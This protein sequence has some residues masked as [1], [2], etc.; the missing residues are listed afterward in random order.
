MIDD[1]VYTNGVDDYI[2][3]KGPKLDTCG[4]PEVGKMDLERKLRH[5]TTCCLFI[6]YDWNNVIKGS[7]N[8]YYRNLS[9]NIRSGQFYQMLYKNPYKLYPVSHDYQWIQKRSV[10]D[11]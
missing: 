3:N 8:P 10:K 7:E 1:S 5:I 2:N 11:M 4:I 9:S 6:R